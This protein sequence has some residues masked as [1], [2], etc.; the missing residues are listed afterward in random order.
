MGARVC[1]LGDG[2][3]PLLHRWLRHSVDRGREVHLLSVKLLPEPIDGVQQHRLPGNSALLPERG[4][5]L[6]YG[7]SLP[8]TRQLL[9]AIRPNLV[10]AHYAWGYGL[11][12]ALAS[13]APLVVS[14]WG[15]D[16]LGSA[17]RSPLHAQAMKFVLRRAD[18][19][20]ATSRYMAVEAA[21]Y[22]TKDVIVTP[23]GVDCEL[24]RPRTSSASRHLTI[25]M[26]KLLTPGSG[27]G[28]LLQAASRLAIPRPR[29]LVVGRA[30]TRLWEDAARALGI[31][32][33]AFFTGNVP[34]AQ[35]PRL[36]Q[37]MDV[38]VAPSTHREGFGVAV[39]EAQACGLPVVASRIGGLPETV[40]DE[41]TGLLV[42]PGDVG[43]LAA[44][45]DML[46]RDER[47]RAEMGAA[48]REFVRNHFSWEKAASLMDEVYARALG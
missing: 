6:R 22:T 48:A 7:L 9:R 42:P 15:S 47:R 46:S 39:L 34:P 13:P 35:V 2:S 37:E 4:R 16:L 38:Y 17:G 8:A 43:A 26:V 12:G 25:G 29:L 21:R 18:H 3:S 24:F 23:F 20:C 36:L 30:E 45:L 33:T 5:G 28:I 41:V 40:S 10:H 27:V 32:D 44:A 14:L 31:A 11:L 19:V 1:Y